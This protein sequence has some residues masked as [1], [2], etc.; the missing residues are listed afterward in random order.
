PMK[1]SSQTGLNPETQMDPSLSPDLPSPDRD[2]DAGLAPDRRAAWSDALRGTQREE[3]HYSDFL[4]AMMST[5]IALHD[6]LLRSAFQRF[7]VDNEGYVT[8]K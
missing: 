1:H 7:D 5:R 2:F 3:I 8:K 6:D 4:A